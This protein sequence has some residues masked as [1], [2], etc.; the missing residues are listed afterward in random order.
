MCGMTKCDFLVCGSGIAGAS[1]AYELAASGASVVVVEQED[2]HGYHTTGR[3][4]AMYL[5]S[6]GA[7]PL[8][9]LTV[10]SR[11][12]FDSPPEGF[13][14]Y[15]LLRPRGCLN[16]AGQESLGELDALAGEIEATGSRYERLDGSQVRERIPILRPDA[17]AAAVYEPDA[18]DID[19][20][21]LHAGYL[22]LARARGADMRLSARLMALEPAAQGWRARLEDGGVI[23]AA[24]VV[25][26]AG[27]WADRVA[28]MAGAAPLG[29]QPLRRT[30]ILL[31][32]PQGLDIAAWPVVSDI[33][34]AFYFK[35][36]A[37]MILASPADETPSDPQDAAPDELDIAVCVDR[38][39]RAADLPARRVARSWAG[40]R[41]FAPDRVPVFGYDPRATGFFWF[42]GQGGYGMQTAPAAARLG[43]ALARG[44]GAPEDL[45]GRGFL[46][47]QVSPARF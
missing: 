17:C 6:Y 4:A 24:A 3:S 31:D 40:L 44:E 33:D 37:G 1:I 7:A 5:E 34:E 45:V 41:T 10:A 43:A 21:A 36:E 12:F 18:A 11:A 15:P 47:E 20:N 13:S 25:N 16:I 42:A 30:I 22:K 32:P 23:E 19:A 27:A 38:L 14:D 26:A 35:P 39:Q 28:A 46:A 8:R 29:L 9:R 2:R